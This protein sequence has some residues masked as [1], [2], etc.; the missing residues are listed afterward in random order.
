[1]SSAAFI[2]FEPGT[3]GIPITEWREFCDEHGIVHSPNTVGGNVFYANQVE[4]TFGRV[5]RVLNVATPALP[6]HAHYLC[7]STYFMGEA[8]PDVAALALAA[9]KR[10]GGQLSAAPEITA[11]FSVDPHLNNQDRKLV[12]VG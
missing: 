5:L 1:M 7:F 9:W 10:W 11:I 2:E 3:K 12:P 6:D 4:V 8:L